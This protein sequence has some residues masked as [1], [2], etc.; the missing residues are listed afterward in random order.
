MKKILLTLLVLVFLSAQFCYSAQIA[1]DTEIL[2]RINERHTSESLL[3]KDCIKAV[4]VSDFKIN[5]KTIFSKGTEVLFFPDK[6]K[7]RGFAGKG[8]YI[9]I[10]SGI[11]KDKSG[12]E[13]RLSTKQKIQGD[14]RDWVIACMGL[15]T[16]TIILI[17]L[18]VIGF[19]KGKSAVIEEGKILQCY[20]A[21]SYNL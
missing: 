16:A 10:R 5:N 3:A 21:E 8:G 9:E 6:V 14:D 18:D 13:Y 1:K 17:P 11:I 7:K 4:T 15:F 12:S 2:V 19:V 20:F